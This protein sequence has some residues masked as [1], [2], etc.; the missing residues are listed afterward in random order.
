MNSEL[1]KCP[2]CKGTL[3]YQI[4]G[5]GRDEHSDL[6]ALWGELVGE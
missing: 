5:Y 6:C 3:V 2:K 4:R 1:I